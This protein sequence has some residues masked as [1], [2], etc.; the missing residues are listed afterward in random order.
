[1]NLTV[2]PR[3]VSLWRLEYTLLL[4][5]TGL[6]LGCIA[7]FSLFFSAV[8]QGTAL[9][10]YFY[11]VLDY[12]PRR[13]RNYRFHAGKGKLTVCCGVWFRRRYTLSLAHIQAV[14]VRRSPTQR[15]F[16]LC[17]VALAL[18]GTRLVLTGLETASCRALIRTVRDREWLLR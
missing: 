8:L 13:A 2:S 16:G 1:M 15:L 4:G 5:A 12:A 10:V 18:P 9:A 17:S 7:V 11:L 3:A 6:L 14:Q